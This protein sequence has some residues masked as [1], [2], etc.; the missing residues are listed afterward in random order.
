ME[1]ENHHWATI[2]VIIISTKNHQWLLKLVAKSLNEKQKYLHSFKISLHKI[3][4]NSIGENSK[5]TVEKPGRPH[6]NKVMDFTSPGMKHPKAMCLLRGYTKKNQ[7]HF[8]GIPAAKN[9]KSKI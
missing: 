7:H 6:W 9:A 1:L 3:L 8:C 2:I 4:N 5:F